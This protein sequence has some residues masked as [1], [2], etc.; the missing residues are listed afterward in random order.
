MSIWSSIGK[1]VSGAVKSVAALD[2]TGV[3]GNV[4]NAAMS[5]IDNAVENQQNKENW[6]RQTSWQ[7]QMIAQN[8]QFNSAEAE[9]ARK[10]NSAEAEKTRQFNSAE[11]EKAHQRNI[12]LFNM[13]NEYNSPAAQVERMRKAGINPAS[14]SGGSL[15][16]ASASASSSAS[17][18]PASG[19]PA[20]AGGVPSAPSYQNP[21]S[22]AQYRLLNEQANSLNLDNRKKRKQIIADEE[23]KDSPF[24]TFTYE[25]APDGTV[26]Y[27]VDVSPR[28]NAYQEEREYRRQQYYSQKLSNDEKEILTSVLR[29][30][31]HL[32]VKG[33]EQE[34][35]KL[36]KEI[37]LLSREDNI[38]ARDEKLAEY[39]IRPESDGFTNL[40][41]ILL[42]S[43]ENGARLLN[44]LSES[45]YRLFKHKFTD[46]KHLPERI[47]ELFSDD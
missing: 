22:I 39:G 42:S 26:H 23:L 20:S 31:K 40:F 24:D 43:P 38:K 9:K 29:D 2:P 47:K 35:H 11:A 3:F 12:D 33:K 18:S 1:V 5:P 10:F 46:L 44:A 6:R 21:L 7:E 41:S 32:L 8:Q 34:F 37:S 13:E 30:T 16:P 28:K 45:A 17:S 14:F 27:T 15:V 36:L 4:A 19:S 25:Q